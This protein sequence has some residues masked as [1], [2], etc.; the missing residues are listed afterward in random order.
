MNPADKESQELERR[1]RI[2]MQKAGL[3]IPSDLDVDEEPPAEAMAAPIPKSLSDIDAAMARILGPQDDAKVVKFP[4]KVD[5]ESF[6]IAARNGKMKLSE[7]TL[8][9][10]QRKE[11]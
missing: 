1:M 7:E 9:K 2:A 4:P 5:E 11:D 3:I 6:A 10:L 8:K